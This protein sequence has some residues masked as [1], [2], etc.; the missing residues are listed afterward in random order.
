MIRFEHVSKRYDDGTLAVDDLSLECHDAEITVLV[1]SSGCGKTTSLRM[2]NRMVEPS[3]GTVSLDG[4]DVR[5]GDPAELRRRMG[6]VIQQGG[7]VPHR[8][9]EDNIATVPRLLGSTRRLARRRAHELMS[10]V[11]LNPELARR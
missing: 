9:V 11:G 4:V 3:S 8:T 1:G 2:I 5:S 10:L 6:Y 7:L